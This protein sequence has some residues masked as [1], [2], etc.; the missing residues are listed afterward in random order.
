MDYSVSHFAS[1][2]S[3]IL[4]VAKG[5]EKG[6]SF[7]ARY[8]FVFLKETTMRVGQEEIQNLEGTLER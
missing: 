3:F 2:R 4:D 8:G 1:A 6:L 5:N 7:Y